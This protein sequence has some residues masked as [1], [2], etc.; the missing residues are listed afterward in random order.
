ML[1]QPM[2]DREIEE[3][4]AEMPSGYMYAPFCGFTKGRQKRYNL[5][6]RHRKYTVRQDRNAQYQLMQGDCH[7]WRVSCIGSRNGDLP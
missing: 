1:L 7:I 6:N 5:N 2:S 4:M 3:M